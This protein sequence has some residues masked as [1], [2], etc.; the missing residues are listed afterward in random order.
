MTGKKEEEKARDEAEDVGDSF[1]YNAD[2]VWCG[3]GQA[4]TGPERGTAQSALPGCLC[5]WIISSGG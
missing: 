4:K 3:V 2:V 1:E 5:R